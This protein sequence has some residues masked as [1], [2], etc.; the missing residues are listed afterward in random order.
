M[1]NWWQWIQHIPAMRE[2]LLFYSATCYSSRP[3]MSRLACSKFPPTTSSR[4]NEPS[5][6]FVANCF[7]GNAGFARKMI[8]NPSV[9]L[10]VQCNRQPTLPVEAEGRS[11]GKTDATYISA[12]NLKLSC[13]YTLTWNPHSAKH[14][15]KCLFW[16]L[17]ISR[18]QTKDKMKL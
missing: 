10:V 12:S 4:R 2:A 8:I 1:C 16:V 17:T 14:F 3:D 15:E 11:T 5:P 13:L 18:R 6:S 9:M 7:V